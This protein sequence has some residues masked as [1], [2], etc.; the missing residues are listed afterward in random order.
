[1]TSPSIPKALREQVK[2]RANFRCEYC[3]TSE[4]LSG[5]EGEID[6]IIPRSEGGASQSGNLC[7]ACTSCNGYKQAKTSAID[8]ESGQAVAL[9]HPRQQR[10]EEHFTW[11]SDGTQVIGLTPSGRAT[12]ES[13]RL[14]HPLPVSARAVWVR[15]GYHPPPLPQDRP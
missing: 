11:S 7:L 13:L 3:Q 12:V 1:M 15:A 4:W 6:H 5:I 14:N 9:F 2:H 8:P 10:W